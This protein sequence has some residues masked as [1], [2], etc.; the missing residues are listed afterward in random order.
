[1]REQ[2]SLYPLRA[3]PPPAVIALLMQ[4]YFNTFL[5]ERNL[6]IGLFSEIQITGPVYK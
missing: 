5:V 4:Q 1:M 2:S 6:M 3:K